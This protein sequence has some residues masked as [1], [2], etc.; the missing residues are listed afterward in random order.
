MKRIFGVPDQKIFKICPQLNGL[1]CRPQFWT[2]LFITLIDAICLTWI[3]RKMLQPD[4][5]K[6]QH[7]SNV[8][9]GS[10]IQRIL[11]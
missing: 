4:R 3:I 1:T 6:K 5:T 7:L 2:K 11:K 8:T 9:S 10:M